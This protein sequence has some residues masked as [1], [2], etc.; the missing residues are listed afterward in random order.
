MAG[1]IVQMLINVLGRFPIVG[2][3]IRRRARYPYRHQWVLHFGGRENYAFTQFVRLAAKLKRSAA[4]SST[5]CVPV[6]NGS[7]CGSS[8][9]C[10]DRAEPYSMASDLA[11]RRPDV[12]FHI[13][14]TDNNAA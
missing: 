5:S 8:F 12:P 6:M 9:G 7:P 14:A 11:S 13:T 10:S 1:S 3:P 4:R 2:D